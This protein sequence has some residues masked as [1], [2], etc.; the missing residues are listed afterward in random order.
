MSAGIRRIL[1]EVQSTRNLRDWFYDKNL[2]LQTGWTYE[3]SSG[4]CI[5]EGRLPYAL[6][7]SG[8][9]MLYSKIPYEI[10][11]A[12]INKTIPQKRMNLKAMILL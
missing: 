8:Y 10:S 6:A 5:H 9:S 11:L 4:P 3:S 12:L 7:S 2:D 1:V